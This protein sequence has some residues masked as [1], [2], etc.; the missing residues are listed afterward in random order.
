[1][2]KG[3]YGGIKY[4]G[5]K[6]SVHR[7]IY[8]AANGPTDLHVLHKCDRPLCCNIDHLFAGNDLDNVKDMIAKGRR[9]YGKGER[10]LN[11]KLTD[12]EVRIIKSR[13][14][15]GATTSE[16]ASEFHVAPPTIR[17]IRSGKSWRHIK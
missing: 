8:E 1:M 5:R 14:A 13:I 16:L 11:V 15:G 17:A 12:K 2:G 3:G 6:R 9:V 4:K 7:I 10:S